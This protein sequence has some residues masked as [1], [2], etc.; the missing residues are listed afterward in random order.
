MRRL[1]EHGQLQPLTAGHPPRSCWAKLAILGGDDGVAMGV[2]RRQ[3]LLIAG[4]E[5]VLQNDGPGL[6]QG[7]QV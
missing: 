2:C 4:R 5:P 1:L 3:L 6:Q 7:L